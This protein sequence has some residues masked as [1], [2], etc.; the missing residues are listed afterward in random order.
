[1]SAD[2]RL[3]PGA[4]LYSRELLRLASS[5]PHGDRLDDPRSSATRR[6]PICGSEISADVRLADGRIIALAFR[7]RACAMGQASAA[8][9]RNAGIG[10]SFAEIQ[11]ARAALSDALA[12]NIEF[13]ATWPELSVFEPARAHPGRH[14]AILLPYDAVLAA[15]G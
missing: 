13:A 11:A 9:L 4:Q 6:S 14:A 10:R 2:A 3:R 8:L 5:L 15:V 12:G 1:M 7:A